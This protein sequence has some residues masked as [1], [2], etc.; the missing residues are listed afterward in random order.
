MPSLDYANY[1]KYLDEIGDYIREPDGSRSKRKDLPRRALEMVR[2]VKEIEKRIPPGGKW[3]RSE[4]PKEIERLSANRDFWMSTVADIEREIGRATN[5]PMKTK[6]PPAMLLSETKAIVDSLEYILREV[7]PEG[8]EGIA[9]PQ[10]G[11]RV[12]QILIDHYNRTQASNSILR[13]IAKRIDPTNLEPTSFDGL[14][15]KVASLVKNQA[16][17]RD[18]IREQGAPKSGQMDSKDSSETE[19]K[20]IWLSGR[21]KE[22]EGILDGYLQREEI[23]RN[24]TKESSDLPPKAAEEADHFHTLTNAIQIQ[25]E[26]MN[27]PENDSRDS[28]ISLQAAIDEA[29]QQLR[30]K[31][32]AQQVEIDELKT[33]EKDLR[34]SSEDA[35]RL[36][37]TKKETAIAELEERHEQWIDEL[38]AKHLRELTDQ[39][40]ELEGLHRAEMDMQKTKHDSQ[41]RDT[42]SRHNLEKDRFRD[43]HQSELEEQRGRADSLQTDLDEEV[44]QRAL[45]RVRAQ[46]RDEEQ[47]AQRITLEAQHA[48]K[49]AE[50]SKLH[51][52]ALARAEHD[53]IEQLGLLDG[54]RKERKRIIENEKTWRLNYEKAMR[55]H[56][57]KELEWK[58][59][60]RQEA[61]RSTKRVEEEGQKHRLV[62]DK[63]RTE[64]RTEKARAK[65][66]MKEEAQKHE[67]AIE[68][69]ETEL[70]VQ[71]VKT[72]A[73]VEDE[74]QKHQSIIDKLEIEVSEAK[75]R[76]IAMVND[77]AQKHRSFIDR[78]QFE[79]RE[80]EARTEA[81]VEEEAQKHKSTI[82]KLEIRCQ[83]LQAILLKQDDY[84]GLTDLEIVRGVT[85]KTGKVSI[86]GFASMVSKVTTFSEWEWREDREVWPQE[87]LTA[88]VGTK[89]RRLKKLILGDAIWTSLF[90][91]IFCS[92]FRVLGKEG[93]QLEAGWNKSF[94]AGMSFQR[95]CFANH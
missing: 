14:P 15:L 11:L 81:K 44:R 9:L 27:T 6:V 10:L 56:E 1:G 57:A 79:L 21:V 65:D 74:A 62:N 2:L 73:M 87:T 68:K 89:Q 19:K 24:A 85:P 22:L 46:K 29:T 58:E 16:S 49:S 50:Q 33:T 72:A 71:K 88:L 77:E 80:E 41:T 95:T 34:E 70:H 38:T 69:L 47:E 75:A 82:E 36:A 76:A 37:E 67:I 64:L 78:L 23:M 5:R 66:K 53:R 93:E 59:A 86:V 3:E 35:M 39:E 48:Q 12:R 31:L 4:L 83:K 63:L 17:K 90:E 54:L 30:T 8:R 13:R 26:E 40:A 18:D 28:H 94:P 43:F 32:D 20:T 61:V 25:S 55:D 60:L 45:S 91:L 52:S 51:S 42:E 92:P 7:D 84:S